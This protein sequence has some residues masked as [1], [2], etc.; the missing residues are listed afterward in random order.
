M[1]YTIKAK[2]AVNSEIEVAGDSPLVVIDLLNMVTRKFFST[3][4]AAKIELIPPKSK[5]S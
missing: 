1:A 4:P 5:K 2:F 3:L